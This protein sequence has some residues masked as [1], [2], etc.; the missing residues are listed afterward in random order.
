MAIQA[1]CRLWPSLRRR[2]PSGSKDYTDRK[3]EEQPYFVIPQGAFWP[4]SKLARISSART[5]AEWSQ[6]LP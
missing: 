1:T 2:Q 3:R 6:A 5:I 4:I